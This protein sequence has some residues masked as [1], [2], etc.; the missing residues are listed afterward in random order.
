MAYLV[1]IADVLAKDELFGAVSSEVGDHHLIHTEGL[2][3]T[4]PLTA[5]LVQVGKDWPHLEI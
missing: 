5:I 3:V 1:S 2:A 4:E